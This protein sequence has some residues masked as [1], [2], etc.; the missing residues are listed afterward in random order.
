MLRR[1]LL[2]LLAAA[3][4]YA[5][6]ESA[7][8]ARTRSGVNGTVRRRTPVA[9][10]MAL[11]TAAAT[12]QIAGSPAPEGVFLRAVDQRGLDGRDLGEGQDA[13]ARPV[14]TRHLVVVP[15]DLLLQRAADPLD[16][17]ALDLVGEPVRI[18]DQPAVVADHHSRDPHVAVARI[19]LD[20]GDDRG[21]GVLGLVA[22][23]GDA[24]P[25]QQTAVCRVAAV[26]GPDGRVSQPAASAAPRMTSMARGS[27]RWRSA[28]LD[29]VG[30]GRRRQLV[31]E[32]LVGGRVCQP[33]QAAQCRRAQRRRRRSSGR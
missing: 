3:G 26:S 33:A 20:L 13:V 18:D 32:D 12:G 6:A 5:L 10:K 17:V 23:E 7:S 22:G 9:S 8:A 29:R 1:V 16:D 30:A 4:G 28:E 11:P 24:P 27:Y 21:V 2:V 19:D 31:E 15:G 14:E 25:G